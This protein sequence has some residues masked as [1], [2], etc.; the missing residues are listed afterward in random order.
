MTMK[1]PSLTAVRA[2]EAAARHESITEAAHELCVTPAAVTHQVRALERWLGVDLFIRKA[3]A[4]CLTP[5]GEKYFSGSNKAI[6]L[7]R[8]VSQDVT[9]PNNR[10]SLSIVA[11][12]S[13]AAQWLV[14]RLS[15]FQSTRKIELSLSIRPVSSEK[16]WRT[17]DIGIVSSAETP[18]FLERRPF[19][20]YRIIAVC[21][22]KLLRGPNAIQKISDLQNHPLLHDDGLKLVDGVDWDSW[23]AQAG[24]DPIESNDSI[25]FCNNFTAYRFAADGHG[26]AL[27]KDVLVKNEIARGDLVNPFNFYLNSSRTYD[28]VCSRANFDLKPVSQF[29]SWLQSES[30]RQAEAVPA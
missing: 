15:G 19:M 26:V 16:T 9:N 8:A 11:P 20:S 17:H 25:H 1:L 2:F 5:A 14:P 21:S 10:V 3:S 18:P 22:P 12:P 28:F 23:L 27:A 7:I 30:R 6:D 24:H 29:W 13:F 4:L